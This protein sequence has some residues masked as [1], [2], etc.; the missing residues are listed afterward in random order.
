MNDPTRNGAGG[1]GYLT[2]TAVPEPSAIALAA[3]GLLA[4]GLLG[5]LRRVP[6][7]AGQA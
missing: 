6:A 2:M 4:A 3:A 7:G 5:R 1:F